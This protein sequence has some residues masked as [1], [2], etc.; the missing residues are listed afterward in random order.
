MGGAARAYERLSKKDNTCKQ[1]LERLPEMKT[2]LEEE[3]ERLISTIE[4]LRGDIS[5]RVKWMS[6]MELPSKDEIKLMIND[7]AFTR[8]HLDANQM[9]MAIL[10]RQKKK[11]TDEV[12]TT[13]LVPIFMQAKKNLNNTYLNQCFF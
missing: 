5:K 7:V 12:C 1:Y 13:L 9:K 2:Q 11:R 4:T 3:R 10:H 6:N 8:K